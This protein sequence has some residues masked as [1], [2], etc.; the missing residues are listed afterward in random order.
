MDIWTSFVDLLIAA[1]FAFS[2]IY[3]GNMGLAIITLSLVVRLALLPLSLKL[4]HR[5]LT[6]QLLLKR[7]QPKLERL[8]ARW[9]NNPERLA[10]E[11][12]KLYERHQARSWRWWPVPVDR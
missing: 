5:S 8:K 12:V 1:L 3:G 7:L 11:T 9:R 2:N 6:R 4:D 10:K